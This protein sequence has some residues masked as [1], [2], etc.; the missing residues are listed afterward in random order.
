[1]LL[2]KVCPK[3][4]YLSLLGNQACPHEMLGGEHD[5]EDYQRY[6]YNQGTLSLPLSSLLCVWVELGAYSMDEPILHVLVD[7]LHLLVCYSVSMCVA[8]LL[9]ACC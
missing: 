2:G 6:R 3:L 5:D 8:C 1:M 4:H 7:V 9:L